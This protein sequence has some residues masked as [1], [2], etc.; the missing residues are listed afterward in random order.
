MKIK[1][2]YEVLGFQKEG[3]WSICSLRGTNAQT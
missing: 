1:A 3:H 2:G